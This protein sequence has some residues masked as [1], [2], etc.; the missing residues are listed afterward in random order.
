MY[1]PGDA[2]DDGTGDNV[3]D[4]P[5]DGDRRQLSNNSAIFQYYH[6]MEQSP[7]VFH[8]S[9]SAWARWSGAHWRWWNGCDQSR[10]P[11]VWTRPFLFITVWPTGARLGLLEPVADQCQAADLLSGDDGT[12][13]KS[14]Q[15]REKGNQSWQ[16]TKTEKRSSQRQ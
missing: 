15:A 2:S 16:K 1:R 14:R 7:L 5:L 13:A 12:S 9:S 10:S 11:N 3:R 6:N 4:V 8:T